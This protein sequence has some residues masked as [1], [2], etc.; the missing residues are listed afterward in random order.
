MKKKHNKRLRAVNDILSVIA[1]LIGLYLI[2]L[3][4]LPNLWWW[5]TKRVTVQ[6]PNSVVQ[7]TDNQPSNQKQPIPQGM[8]ITIPRMDLKEHINNGPTFSELNKGIWHLP[9]S[10]TPQQGS[11]TV[12][13][14]HRFTYTSPK[15]VFYFL[16]KIEL[17]DRITVDWDNQEYTYKVTK[18]SIVPP[19]D[20]TLVAPSNN[21]LLTLYTCTPLLTASKRLVVQAELVSK[22]AS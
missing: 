11:N 17:N 18:I 3:P 19:T 14:G 8:L 15:G 2:A 13:A 21:N 7:V 6:P 16:D 12:M 22:R 9:N 5:Y 20:G 10:S 4:Y 1:V